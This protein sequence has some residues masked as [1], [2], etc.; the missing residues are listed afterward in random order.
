MRERYQIE[1]QVRSANL[2]E[3][4]LFR[5]IVH[6]NACSTWTGLGGEQNSRTLLAGPRTRARAKARSRREIALL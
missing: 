3:S 2:H 1:R 4:D 5:M 6:R